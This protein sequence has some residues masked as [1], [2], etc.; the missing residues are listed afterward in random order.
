MDFLPDPSDFSIFTI[1]VP[2]TIQA[3]IIF[4]IW[5]PVRK[6]TPD[7]LVTA[8][9]LTGGLSFVAFISLLVLVAVVGGI[10]FSIANPTLR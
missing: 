4:M 8:I 6:R 3:A 10:V 1:I 5:I 7:K 2:L 9:C